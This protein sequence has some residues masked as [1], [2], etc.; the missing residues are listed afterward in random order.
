MNIGFLMD[1]LDSINPENETTS[2]LMYECNQRGHAV[3]FLE[4][5]DVYIRKNEVVARMRNITVPADLSMKKYWRALL[6]C[7]KREELIFETVTDLDALFLRKNPPLIYQTMEFLSSVND[8]VFMINS[9][10]GQILANSKLYTLNFPEIIPETHVSRDPNRLKKIIDDFG[11]AMVVKPLQ[12]YGGEGVIKVSVRDRENLIS[13][14]NYYVRAYKSYPEREP[15]MV[16]EYLD[17]VKIEGDVRILMLNGRI[18]GAMR[19]K[20]RK[21]DFRTNIHAGAKAYK[22]KV[23]PKEKE[24]CAA[25]K[26]RL[27]EDGLF[28][29]GID[30]IG[31]KLVEINCVSPGGIPRINR[32]NKV[33]LEAE[34]VDFIEQK[35]EGMKKKR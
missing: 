10:R 33:K 25:I 1:R 28:F 21:G 30:I 7:L 15:I 12:R 34:V 11:G 22:H 5:H 31:D 24:I 4:P 18:L 16:Q 17:G 23:T 13:L 26:G 9:T 35:V 6:S 2:H 8:R 29:V 20:P 27:V 19:R 14:T 32:L 3:F